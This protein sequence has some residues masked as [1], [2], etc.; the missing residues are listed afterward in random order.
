MQKIASGQSFSEPSVATAPHQK[1][2]ASEPFQVGLVQVWISIHV[3]SAMPRCIIHGF[4]V[5]R[6]RAV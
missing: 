3:T 1:I 2:D 4:V 5:T 6:T